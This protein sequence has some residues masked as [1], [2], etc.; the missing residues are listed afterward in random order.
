[1]KPRV[2]VRGSP[3]VKAR[4][5]SRIKARGS[6]GVK[7]RRSWESH[8]ILS[9][10]LKSVREY[11][12]VNPHTPKATPTLGDGVPMDSQHFKEPLQGSKLNGL[13]RFLYHWKDPKT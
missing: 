7:A 1:M 13:W 4:G 10:V 6:S 8:H 2:K 3:G 5:S 12:G 9:G 11:E